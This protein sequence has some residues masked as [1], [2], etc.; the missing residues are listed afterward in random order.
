MRATSTPTA[1][2][3][4]ERLR[5]LLEV[6]HE[7]PELD[8]KSSFDHTSTRAW[9]EFAKDVAAML[10]EGGD[11]I[12]G[13]D[14]K[15]NLTGDVTADTLRALDESCVRAKVGK[16]IDEP[17]DIRVAA[18]TV[19]GHHVVLV[20][21]EPHEDGCCILSA[22]GAYEDGK[23]RK[24]KELFRKG[25]ILVRHGTASERASQHDIR[26]ILHRVVQM[27]KEVWRS[28]FFEA[29]QHELAVSERV[30]STLHGTARDLHWHLDSEAFEG[31]IIESIRRHDLIPIRYC[32]NTAGLGLRTAL[33]G[34]S[35]LDDIETIMDRLT[36]VGALAITYSALETLQ[37]ALDALHKAYVIPLRLRAGSRIA[38]PTAPYWTRIIERFVA[39]GALTVRLKRWEVVAMLVLPPTS[40]DEFQDYSTII[41][42][43]QVQGARANYFQRDVS[44]RKTELC[45][46]HT[47]I[48]H[49]ERL[50]C[51]RPD[52]DAEDEEI[53]DSLCQF[54]F[55]AA[56]VSLA[57]QSGSPELDYYPNFSRYQA[58][59]INA[60]VSNVITPGPL[61]SAVFPKDD[62]SLAD[63]LVILAKQSQKISFRFAGW[64]GYPRDVLTFI[65]N[66]LPATP[67]PP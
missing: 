9:C 55:L 51:L 66:A 38:V 50:E 25:D 28:E 17:F 27:R 16:W 46:L 53:V 59:R 58:H 60:V 40:D 5:Q 43:G 26:K 1:H 47:A 39:L 64:D 61:R 21:V 2:L 15:G 34:E 31:A 30:L 8:Y 11:L 35:D 65:Q 62:A 14:D 4:E 12:I 6:G 57:S 36:C 67:H 19:E 18:H 45:L 23:T 37:L 13:A 63:A 10:A 22:P 20:H 33:K 49:I 41:R 29:R 42:H 44:G 24:T 54:D 56:L 3:S 7:G 32:V 48:E 52:T